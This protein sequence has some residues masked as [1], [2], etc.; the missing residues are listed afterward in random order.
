M[1]CNLF[2]RLFWDK[3]GKKSYMIE[4]KGLYLPNQV[5]ILD[6]ILLFSLLIL[7][8]ANIDVAQVYSTHKAPDG[9]TW[10]SRRKYQYY[11]PAFV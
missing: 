4:R 9:S 1:F 5:L 7:C 2:I 3:G 10:V 11:F 6:P 8:V